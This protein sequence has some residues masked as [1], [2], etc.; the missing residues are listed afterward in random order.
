MTWLGKIIGG[1][2]GYSVAGPIGLLLG[3]FFGHSVDKTI[4][5]NAQIQGNSWR[6]FHQ[7]DL[8][9]Y[10]IDALFTVM[11][12]VAKSDGRVSEEEIHYARNIMANMGLSKSATHHAI[13]CFNRGKE[14]AFKVGEVI[15][16]LR[17]HVPANHVLVQTLLE[18]LLGM[19]YVDGPITVHQR[20]VLLQ[21]CEGLGVSQLDFDRLEAITRAQ[22]EFHGG[23]QRH[24]NDSAYSSRGHAPRHS[25]VMSITEAYEVLE[26]TASTSDDEVKKAYRRLMSRHHPDKLMAQGVSEE[27]IKLATSK[28]QRIKA[29]YDVVKEARGL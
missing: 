11:G 9:K 16:K 29:A 20:A 17:E 15:T 25:E 18:L 3:V 5:D 4:S 10:Y 1:A 13:E 2:F 14:S 19:A 24:Y 8:T 27:M 7:N 22:R 28:A 23:Y 21:V 26:V 6:N 12:H